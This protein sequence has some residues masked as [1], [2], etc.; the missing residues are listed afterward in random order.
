MNSFLLDSKVEIKSIHELEEAEQDD[1]ITM[2][3]I[4]RMY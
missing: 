2:I 3:R 4:Q 1:R